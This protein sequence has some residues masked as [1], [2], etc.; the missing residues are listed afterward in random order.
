[1]QNAVAVKAGILFFIGI[2][3]FLLSEIFRGL[4]SGFSSSIF[5]G[6]FFPNILILVYCGS[7]S[8]LLS[9]WLAFKLDRVSVLGTDCSHLLK[10]F[11]FFF[12]INHA[13]FKVDFTSH[14]QLVASLSLFT[15]MHWYIF[16]RTISGFCLSLIG[17][18]LSS[19]LFN[20]L[21]FKGIYQYYDPVMRVWLPFLFFSGGTTVG[22]VGKYLAQTDLLPN[23]RNN[24]FKIKAE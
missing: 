16:D 19:C 4:K 3:F 7:A 8:G 2:A 17:A 22:L 15:A 21:I 14:A 12:G 23:S 18:L 24:A 5:Q 13:T 20:L 1:M 11:I 6:I 10:C 9:P